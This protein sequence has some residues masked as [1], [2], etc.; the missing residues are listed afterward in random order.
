MTRLIISLILISVS[1]GCRKD[2]Q[3]S[4][5]GKDVGELINALR[6]GKPEEKPAV[7]LELSRRGPD[8]LK[9]LPALVEALASDDPAFRQNAAIALGK[10]GPT[11][12]AAVDPLIEA[13]ADPEWTVRRNA[14][15]A[16]GEIGDPRAL[17][18][19]EGLSRD[20]DS[21]V[22]K[23]AAESAKRLRQK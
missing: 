4:L 21:L 3:E 8:S 15:M 14:A 9:A 19:V 16:L 6:N 11:A 22:R 13:L 2:K 1:L 18:S 23:A 10:I 5:R 12:T 7:A 17:P 20:S